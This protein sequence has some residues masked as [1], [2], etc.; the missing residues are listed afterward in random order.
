MRKH[1]K[2]LNGIFGLMLT[3]AAIAPFAYASTNASNWTDTEYNLQ[4]I[5]DGG[6]VYTEVRQKT[7]NS[8]VYIL[9]KGNVDVSVAVKVVGY[10]G[11][12]TAM[13]GQ[14]SFV[15]VPKGQ[16]YMITN[17]VAE[18]F[19][20][21]NGKDIYLELLPSVHYSTWIYG[22]WSPDSI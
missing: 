4:Y 10:I 2:L 22:L 11:N 13:Y 21:F 20:N 9:H 1:N 5:G 19:P 14:G 15:P 17:Y 8:Y 18:S 16:G 12:Y 3:T 7:D 6:D